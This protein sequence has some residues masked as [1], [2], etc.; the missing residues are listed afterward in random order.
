[1]KR[2]FNFGIMGTG[3]IARS[4]AE[5]VNYC[6][7]SKL[8]AVCSR[9]EEKAKDFAKEFLAEKYYGNYQQL[10]Q[11]RGIDVIYIATPTACH[12]DNAKMCL[13]HGKNVICEKAVTENTGQLEEL[14][15]LAKEKDVFFMEAMW[16]KCRP[17]FLQALEWY[18]SGKIGKIKMINADFS[19]VTP[20]DGEDRL[21]KKELGASALL[22]LGIY[23]LSLF[24]A[25]LGNTPEKIT[26][27]LHIGKTLAD[28]DG[29]VT[30]DFGDSFAV[31]VFG[32]SIEN[33]NNCVIVGEKGRI[34]FPQWFF[35]TDEVCLYDENAR[36]VEKKTM[37][38]RSN[39][40]E[41][42]VEEVC[43]CLDKGLRQSRLVP[44]TD[45]VAVMKIMDEVFEQNNA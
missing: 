45:T 38:N 6:D 5:A 10:C 27:R 34:V 16:M 22:D 17:G 2:V 37:Q 33:N 11:D 19:M 13:E 42:E 4:F 1:M 14:L 21:F 30:L 20:F 35:C 8:Y 9:S 24:T 3:R 29:T 36:L 41:Y 18:K 12:F 40:Y 43:S 26:S 15:A 32:Y 7:C 28:F 39:G 31:T 44:H 25:F 23:P